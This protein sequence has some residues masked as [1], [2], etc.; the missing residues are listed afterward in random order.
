M[1]ENVFYSERM[2]S[3]NL[4]GHLAENKDNSWISNNTRYMH[5]N[6]MGIPKLK[7]LILKTY[8]WVQSCNTKRV[9]KKNRK[10]SKTIF[11]KWDS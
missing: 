11:K 6:H 5:G 8:T 4:L 9:E 3:S 1:A 7:L 2:A 10:I